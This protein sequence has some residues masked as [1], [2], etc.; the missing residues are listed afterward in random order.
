[1]HR[2][3]TVITMSDDRL[4]TFFLK[5]H[6]GNVSLIASIGG[7][8]LQSYNNEIA[9]LNE[10]IGF[11]FHTQYELFFIGE[12]PLVIVVNETE[13]TLQNTAFLIPPFVQHF[14]KTRVDAYSLCFEF[15]Q[16]GTAENDVHA[17]IFPLFERSLT[18]L[19]IDSFTF[20]C[21]SRL[22]VAYQK[23]TLF[24]TEEARALLKLIFIGLYENNVDMSIGENQPAIND[25]FI[26]ID[27]LIHTRY[28]QNI[29][30]ATIAE[31][32]HLSTKQTSRIIRKKYRVTLSELLNEKRLSVA[33]LML[34]NT[35]K[36][37]AEIAS[38]VFYRSENYFFRLFREKY[39]LSPLAYRKKHQSS[40]ES[41]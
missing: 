35:D 30:L 27:H 4:S 23:S 7:K 13:Y 40:K 34:Q 22:K 9:T 18:P 11:H 12:A 15:K 2:K 26:V 24:S 17:S 8:F 19:K 20:D 36:P 37:I 25:Y 1:M 14:V 3:G 6:V 31:A 28:T 21:L 33:A 5:T 39:G 32:L 41:N 10:V 29:T 16:T 38:H